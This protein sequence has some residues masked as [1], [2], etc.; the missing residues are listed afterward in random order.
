MAGALEAIVLIN[1]G[2]IGASAVTLSTA[3]AFGDVFKVKHS[4]HRSFR[5]ARGFYAIYAL[6]VVAVA[7]IV[8]IP[9]APLGL[10]TE[11]VQALA[12]SLL[13]IWLVPM[14]TGGRKRG[15]ALP[16]EFDWMAWR[17]PPLEDLPKPVWSVTRTLG[18]YTLRGYLL[19]AAAMLIVKVVR[20]ALTGQG[21][22]A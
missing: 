7:G 11:A 3:Y 9:D 20:L 10:L 14:W 1:A 13:V 6:S 15:V 8:L 19:I 5:D 18:M 12:L 22:G 17:M 16:P 2:I 21:T 4:L